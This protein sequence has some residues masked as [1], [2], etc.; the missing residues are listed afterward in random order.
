MASPGSFFFTSPLGERRPDARP[1]VVWLWGEHDASTDRALCLTLARAIAVDTPGLVLDL[2]E[3]ESMGTSTLGTI[4]RARRFLRL[5]SA[6]LT[7]R[8]PSGPA[9]S[10][11]DDCGLSDLL[12]AGPEMTEA[13]Q[14]TA[15]G[16]WVA[17]P[18]VDRDD[19][20]PGSSGTAPE[21]APA[22]V[23][24]IASSQPTGNERGARHQ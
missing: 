18:A 17:L 3:V 23:G 19:G 7:V 16:S 5:H 15:L 12:C 20:H 10:L 24:E 6:S 4:L 21:R 1:L 13:Q 8:S 11:I 14:A 22:R 9:L 2:S